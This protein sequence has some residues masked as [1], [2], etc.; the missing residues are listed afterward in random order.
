MDIAM[1]P[2]AVDVRD[3]AEYVDRLG[4]LRVWAGRPSFRRLALLAGTTTTASGHVV[5]RPPPST[6]TDTL[7]GKRLPG[8][9]RMELVEAFVAACLE[10]CHLPADVIEHTV[11]QW[12]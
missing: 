5:D 2:T 4:R 1:A 9:P 12:L 3:A 11:E 10:A 8:L 6:V 7:N